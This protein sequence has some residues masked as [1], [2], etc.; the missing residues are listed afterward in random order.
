M[1]HQTNTDLELEAKWYIEALPDTMFALIMENDI[2]HH[3][4][5][6]LRAH[7]KEAK[8]YAHNVYYKPDEVGDIF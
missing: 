8:D 3:D 2:K 6:G 4:L 1:S 7:L 5:E